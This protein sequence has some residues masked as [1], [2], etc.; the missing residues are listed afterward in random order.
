V[1]VSV[2]NDNSTFCYGSGY[3]AGSDSIPASLASKD[4]RPA[5]KGPNGQ[6][7]KSKPGGFSDEKIK[8]D[9]S[10]LR[11][12]KPAEKMPAG[13]ISPVE[14][15]LAQNERNH[16]VAGVMRRRGNVPDSTSTNLVLHNQQRPRVQPAAVEKP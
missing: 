9:L 1:D 2:V 12:D 8:Q 3:I 7:T 10:A 4:N 11:N 14:R 15:L 6:E 16:P 13:V 5:P